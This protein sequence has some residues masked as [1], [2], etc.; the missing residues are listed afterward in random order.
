MLNGVRII[1]VSDVATIAHCVG[2]RLRDVS[3]IA[4]SVG[5]MMHRFRL[6]S[7]TMSDVAKGIWSA[8]IAF[9]KIEQENNDHESKNAT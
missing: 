8:E 1:S 5:R 7:A 9:S 6:R 3:A 4:R 2:R